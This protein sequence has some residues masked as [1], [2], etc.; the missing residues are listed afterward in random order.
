MKLE[1]KIELLKF[2]FAVL[3]SIFLVLGLSVMGCGVWILFNTGSFLNVLSSAELRVA[4]AGLFM[5][6]GVVVLIS[7][8]GCVGATMENRI[9]LLVYLVFLV[10]L[11]LGQL[12]VTFLLLLNKDKIN[13]SLTE[14]L[15]QIISQY[16]NSSDSSSRVMDNVQKNSKCCGRTGPADWLKNSF[17]QT[18]NLTSPDVLPCSCFKSV[19]PTFNSSW[20]SENSSFTELGIEEGIESFNQSCGQRI[21]GWLQENILT[22]VAM[23]AILILL[24]MVE[25][26]IGALLFR[27]FGEKN[28]QVVGLSHAHLD[29]SPDNDLD[30][31]EQNYAFHN[32]DEDP[33][34][35]TA[36]DAS[37]M[38]YDHY[39]QNQAQGYQD[40]VY[41]YHDY[42]DQNQ[43]YQE[44]A[45][46]Y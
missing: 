40:P 4:A 14:T 24:Q 7:L 27:M 18:L 35:M 2:C 10:V 36:V 11:V 45:Q 42:Q 1:V 30:S 22:I 13:Q 29:S 34:Y 21:S 19:Q 15:D 41:C 16:G 12:F 37:N 28:K 9:L 32:P 8:T 38:A 3:N 33:N 26:S 6:G 43:G 39:N 20:C 23:G 17:I 44:A 25:L 31:G 46:P 5:I